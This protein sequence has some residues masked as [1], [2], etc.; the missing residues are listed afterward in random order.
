MA[1]A[2]DTR[3]A[4]SRSPDGRLLPGVALNPGGKPQGLSI[5]AYIRELVGSR[6]KFVEAMVAAAEK[7]NQTLQ[8]YLV[9]RLGGKAVQMQVN[10]NIGADWQTALGVLAGGPGLQPAE[11][12]PRATIIDA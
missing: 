8:M 7:G 11:A 10:V 6:P 2:T 12:A 5:D 4:P 3:P 9:D 1:E